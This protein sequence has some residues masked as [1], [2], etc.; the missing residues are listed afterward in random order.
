MFV[1]HGMFLN[2]SLMRTDIW[3]L[4]HFWGSVFI[5]NTNIKSKFKFVNSLRLSL[6]AII[7][8][9]NIRDILSDKSIIKMYD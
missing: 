3:L 2:V 1:V 5:N 7:L 4:D 6:H 9:N 8:S